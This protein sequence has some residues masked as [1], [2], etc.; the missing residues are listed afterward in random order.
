MTPKK[1]LGRG[2]EAIIFL[3]KGFVIKDRIKK[4]YRIPELDDQIRKLR[5]RAEGKSLE[6][7]GK[8]ISVPKV[9]KADE[10]E[11]KLTIEFIKGKKLS[12][13][14]DSFSL[15][16]QKE[17]CKKIGNSTGKLHDSGIVHGDLTTSNMILKNKKVYFI[18][19]G[20]SFNSP[21]YEDRAVDLHL[22]KQALE[23]KH[24]QHWEVLFKEV[25]SEYKKASKE[26][27]KTLVQFK[28]VEKRGRYKEH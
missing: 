21:K 18:D 3:E 23:A 26:A 20:L 17:I 15:K 1:I 8:V 28:E 22:L 13:S 6:K 24:F 16:E 5:T 25:S 11:K 2:A 10:K 4:A 27:E 7:A 9:F 14:L 12:D 19:F